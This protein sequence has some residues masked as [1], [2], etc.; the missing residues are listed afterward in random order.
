M[1]SVELYNFVVDDEWTGVTI[2]SPELSM[3]TIEGNPANPFQ[4]GTFQL[5]Y[6]AVCANRCNSLQLNEHLVFREHKLEEYGVGNED[7]IEVLT[8]DEIK[9]INIRNQKRTAKVRYILKGGVTTR[10]GETG[11]TIA[12]YPHKYRELTMHAFSPFCHFVF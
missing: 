10:N 7:M 9:N 6:H 12:K 11:G 8:E 2:N 5:A 4:A 3:L 1:Y